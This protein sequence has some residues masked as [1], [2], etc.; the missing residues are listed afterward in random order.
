MFGNFL[1]PKNKLTFG[2]YFEYSPDKLT[3][4]AEDEDYFAMIHLSMFH[5]I[6]GPSAKYNLE[7]FKFATQMA[8]KGNSTCQN[9]LGYFYQIGLGTSVDYNQSK[10]LFEQAA[11][12]GE[13]T[14][15]Y[16]L[17]ACYLNGRGTEVDYE[18]AKKYFAEASGQTEFTVETLRAILSPVLARLLD[19]DNQNLI[20]MIN[21]DAKKGNE[22][23]MQC[24]D[25]F[26]EEFL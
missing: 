7:S 15:K 10:K 24:I 16:S 19:L 1:N 17:A 26:V 12:A 3:E 21:E 25:Y 2:E 23:A 20:E 4:M 22:N 14:A 18:M 6:E 13:P 11:D 5:G 8:N 9:I